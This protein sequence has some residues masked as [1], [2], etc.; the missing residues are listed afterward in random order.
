MWAKT[1][2][3]KEARYDVI[4]VSD[5]LKEYALDRL[6]LEVRAEARAATSP[7]GTPNPR[8]P[9]TPQRT[10]RRTSA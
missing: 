1:M 4:T 9:A 2:S 7:P 8:R 5:E 6:I 10:A 3:I